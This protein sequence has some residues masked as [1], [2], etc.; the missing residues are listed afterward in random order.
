MILDRPLV[1]DGVVMRVKART[2][3]GHGGAV[4]GPTSPI[5]AQDVRSESDALGK[6]GALLFVA[7]AELV[8][9]NAFITSHKERAGK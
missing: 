8:A 5:R 3:R 2:R 9:R 7:S 4:E 6:P 1:T